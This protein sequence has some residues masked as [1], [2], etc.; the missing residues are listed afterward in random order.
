MGASQIVHKKNK[1]KE[2]GEKFNTIF[3]AHFQSLVVRNDE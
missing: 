1:W 3:W 2:K